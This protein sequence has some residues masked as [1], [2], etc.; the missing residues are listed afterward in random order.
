MP[1]AV[2]GLSGFGLGDLI[3]KQK[4]F[5]FLIIFIV[6]LSK[7]AYAKDLQVLQT[8]SVKVLFE[9]PLKSAAKQVADLYP[10]VK[11]NLESNFGW[12]LNLSPSVILIKDRDNFLRMAGDPLVVAFAVPRRNLIVI[13]YSKMTTHPFSFETTL[14]HELCHILLHKHIK[15]EI[16]PRWLDEG[17]C[18]WASGGIGEIIM[19]PKRSF[20]NRAALSKKFIRL[21]NL[22]RVFPP[23]KNSR[24]LAY[25]QSKSFVSYLVR[26]FGRDGILNVLKRMKAGEITEAAFSRVFLIPLE[27]LENEWRDSLRQKMTWFTYLSYYLYEILFTLMAL[28]TICAFIRLRIK[29]KGYVDDEICPNMDNIY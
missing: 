8:S 1:I 13:D 27:E 9:P 26:R 2:R 24:L 14:K 3:K 10:G 6:A 28:I 7:C 21:R 25:E 17:L 5:F 4:R 20:L 29:K 16:F 12:E 22:E 15:V 23:D 18:Q 19:D 11:E